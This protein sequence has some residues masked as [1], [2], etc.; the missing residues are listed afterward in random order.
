MDNSEVAAIFYE[1]ADLLDLQ[2]VAFKPNAYRRAARSIE[3]LSED[4]SKVAA[5]GRI[6]EIPGVGKSM[7]KK[8]EE[9]LMTGHLQFLNKLRSQVPPGLLELLSVPDV[10]PK[11][12]SLLYKELGI[13]D[14]EH[15]K[16][17]ALEHRLR[18]LKGFGEKAE[19]RILQGI[20]TLEAK[21]GRILLGDAL[22]VASK[23]VA[24]M[25]SKVQIDLISPAGSLRRGKETVGDIDILVGDDDPGSVMDAFVSYPEV[26]EVAMKGPTKS[27]VVLSSGLQVDV[28]VVESSSYGAALQYFTGSKEHN[29][30]LR[31]IGVEMGLKL[32]EYGVFERESGKR[33]AGQTEK[34][35]YDVLGL[36]LVPPELRED[37]GEIDAAKKGQ[38]PSLVEPSHIRGD[39]HVHSE[40][41][42]GTGSIA[43]IAAEAASR[44]YEYV[45][46]SDHSQS[47]KITN[48]LTPDRLRKQI[49]EV[50]K[51]ED[52][53]DGKPRVLAGSEV[54][55]KADGSLD[56]PAGVLRDLDFVIGSVHSR[57]KMDKADMTRRILTAIDSGW[58]DV[59]GHPTGRIIGHRD[60]FEFDMDKV[61]SEAKEGKVCMEVNC[62]PDRLDLRDS[63]CR[64][65][66][67]AGV[68]IALGTDSHRLEQMDFISLG[69]TTARR[70]WLERADVLN[71]L[72]AK[73]LS[74]HLKRRRP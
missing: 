34:D 22:A 52:Q 16:Q 66:K 28:R 21:G 23:Y 59:L 20:R 18:G 41:S 46:I 71:T 8:I 73:E 11:T 10:G 70:G 12:A 55:I 40:W 5:E 62:F 31:R 72:S 25:R 44:G 50:R 1:V 53:L 58:I 27:S 57:F 19:E 15:L 32:N 42:D 68:M 9:L 51:V 7:A 65:A 74:N 24:Y 43:E 33:I 30:A 69:V 47:L 67:E 64:M 2:G 17:A 61:F 6:E 49:E 48:G 56:Y 35:V 26:R 29:V 54:D 37:S 39:L 45:V 36:P 60:P 3:D 13:S 14:I 38:L 63:H 4:L